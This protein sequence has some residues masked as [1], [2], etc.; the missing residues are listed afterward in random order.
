MAVLLPS[1]LL[2]SAVLLATPGA[3]P[4]GNARGGIAA[5]GQR[6][7]G[8]HQVRLRS[9]PGLAVRHAHELAGQ[10]RT[11]PG[12]DDLADRQGVVRDGPALLAGLVVC[13][14]CGAKMTVRYQRGRGGTLRPAYV[15][16]DY[17]DARC[18]QL[19]PVLTCFW[20]R[21]GRNRWSVPVR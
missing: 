12:L 6:D 21:F 9:D 20:S 11:A 17:G 8:G 1:R 2:C 4:A 19:R 5:S 15:C 16:A 18:Q 14:R 7:R 3:G 10:G 13:G